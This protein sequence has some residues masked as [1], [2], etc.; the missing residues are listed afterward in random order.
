[1]SLFYRIIKTRDDW[2]PGIKPLWKLQI[3]DEEYQE[4]KEFLRNSIVTTY[5]PN[6]ER[7]AVL[8]FSEWWRREYTGGHHKKID[9]ANSMHLGAYSEELFQLAVKGAELLGI[10][11][12]RLEN[13]RF[14]DTLFLQGGLPLGALAKNDG[15]NRYEFYLGNIVKYVSTHYLND[16]ENIE[17]IQ[18][19]NNYISPSF[20]NEVMYDLTLSIVKA[21]CYDDD[22]FFPFNIDD[23]QFEKLVKGLRKTKNE[24]KRSLRENPFTINWF[25]RKQ[26]NQLYLSYKVEYE[27]VLS[28]SWVNKN[29]HHIGD[30]FSRLDLIIEYQDSQKYIR[31]NNG[32]YAASLVGR[33]I[34]GLI[35][36]FNNSAISSQIVTNSNQVF[37]ISI[38]NSD[39]PNFQFPILATQVER[40]ERDSL[41]KITN[42]PIKGNVNLLLCPK[43]W[44]CQNIEGDNYIINEIEIQLFEFENEIEISN[45]SETIRYD[46]NY[47]LDYK[48]DFGLPLIEWIQKS[49]YFVITA[50]PQIRVYDFDD[51]RLNS[52]KYLIHYKLNRESEWQLYNANDNL[53]VGI[54]DFK[55]FIEDR[56]TIRKRFFNCGALEFYITN[57]TLS[58]GEIII[59]W[60]GGTVTPLNIQDG[61]IVEKKNNNSWKISCNSDLKNYPDTISFELKSKEDKSSYLRINVPAPFKGVVLIDP[62]GNVVES[63][64]VIC[65]NALLGY[66]CLVMGHECVPVHIRYFKNEQDKN[67]LEA[68]T[69]FYKGLNNKLQMLEIDIQ[70]IFRV[71]SK[72]FLEYKDNGIFLLQIGR[73]LHFKLDRFNCILEIEDNDICIKDK[74]GNVISDFK[75][76]LFH[77]PLNCSPD[78]ISARQ[79]TREN[80][81]FQIVRNEIPKDEIIVFSSSRK[82]VHLQIRPRYVNLD[83]IKREQSHD[84]IINSIKNELIEGTFEDSVWK[85]ASKYF[86]VTIEKN[87]PFETFNHLT[88]I[89]KKKTLMA[90]FFIYLLINYQFDESKLMNELS[91]FENEFG[92]A[93]HWINYEVWNI[94]IESYLSSLGLDNVY[95]KEIENQLLK[96]VIQLLSFRAIDRE[97]ISEFL[98]LLF[99]KNSQLNFGYVPQPSPR[100]IQFEK[101]KFNNG[102]GI[103]IPE[104]ISNLYPQIPV[105]F[106]HLFKLD[107]GDF[108]QWGGLLLSPLMAALAFTGK[109]EVFEK[110]NYWHFQRALYYLELDSEWYFYVFEIMV[111]KLIQLK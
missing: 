15:A 80:G 90:R 20:Q 97:S 69:Q 37:D 27:S 42:N 17:F 99:S 26:A 22:S 84:E 95:K 79:I 91:R 14:L 12:I 71:N 74:L 103:H 49:N 9:V 77:I 85:V 68:T 58:S 76:D 34:G 86:E 73:E 81:I 59:N 41:W 25:I 100:E 61:L 24:S 32:D 7:E 109:N 33:K 89:S 92:K 29:L 88:A 30:P 48:V 62:S 46:S 57:S 11:F 10:R 50:S 94:T 23:T 3:T 66:R 1:M 78:N 51:N 75:Y 93:W 39:I 5:H 54:L 82:D 65:A 83:G 43:E 105:Q 106:R 19:F 72:S 53:P 13:T 52:K 8:Y 2:R 35:C 16:W 87:L 55:V 102:N 63:G 101:Q 67:P 56:V 111:K 31:K 45:S 44:A 98:N 6:C 21:I 70:T 108:H 18:S 64:Q 28:E 110:N 38:P 36:D 4:L 107:A 47:S 96:K 104:Y 40:N 60:A